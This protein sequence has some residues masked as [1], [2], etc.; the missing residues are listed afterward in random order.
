M[1]ILM[2]FEMNKEAET[3]NGIRVANIE[4]CKEIELIPSWNPGRDAGTLPDYLSI[5]L[6]GYDDTFDT[7]TRGEYILDGTKETVNKALE[8]YNKVIN[9]L[10]V[11]GYAKISDFENVEWD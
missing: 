4:E 9:K 3:Y 7:A 5:F 6:Y 11:N 1:R 8:N 10:L 2:D